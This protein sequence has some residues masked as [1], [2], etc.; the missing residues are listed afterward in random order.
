MKETDQ[1]TLQAMGEVRE[2]MLSHRANEK[3]LLVILIASS[4]NDGSA[5]QQCRAE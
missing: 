3:N 4:P 2:T 5:N 1:G